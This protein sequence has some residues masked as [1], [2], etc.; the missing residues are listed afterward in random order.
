[1]DGS[2]RTQRHQRCPIRRS[3]DQQL[4]R[5]G[6][7]A[8]LR[9]SVPVGSNAARSAL[10]PRLHA[11]MKVRLKCADATGDTARCLGRRSSCRRQPTSSPGCDSGRNQT[12]DSDQGGEAGGLGG[13]LPSGVGGGRQLQWTSPRSRRGRG[14]PITRMDGRGRVRATRTNGDIITRSITMTSSRGASG[15][16]RGA[17]GVGMSWGGQPLRWKIR[18]VVDRRWVHGQGRV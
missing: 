6:R 11:S 10:R 7:E 8:H 13:L 17:G 2:L 9:G 1:M 3:T 16:Y 14:V 18:D 12:S 5:H 15:V 4:W